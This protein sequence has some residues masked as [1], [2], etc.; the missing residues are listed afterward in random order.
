MK[1]RR[2]VECEM[3]WKEERIAFW[4]INGRMP[5]NDELQIDCEVFSKSRGALI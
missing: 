1:T 3:K 5:R 4:E 2:S